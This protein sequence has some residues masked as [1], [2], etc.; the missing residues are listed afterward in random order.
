MTSYTALK[1]NW[2]NIDSLS[3]RWIKAD[4]MLFECCVPVEGSQSTAYVNEISLAT[5]N[6]YCHSWVVGFSSSL[7]SRS[8]HFLINACPE[9]YIRE[10]Q[11]H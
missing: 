2:T 4:L 5:K 8:L 3:W 1:Q 7:W 6:Y 11:Y 10:S 9:T